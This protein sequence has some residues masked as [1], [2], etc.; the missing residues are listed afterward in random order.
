MN[1]LQLP[2]ITAQRWAAVFS[3]TRMGLCGVYHKH[4]QTSLRLCLLSLVHVCSWLLWQWCGECRLS[5][6]T[7]SGKQ[8]VHWGTTGFKKQRGRTL[9][10]WMFGLMWSTLLTLCAFTS[11]ISGL[12]MAVTPR[13][14]LS[15]LLTMAPHIPRRKQ[16][17]ID[18]DL[19]VMVTSPPRCSAYSSSYQFL[20]LGRCSAC[21]W[22]MLFR[23][24]SL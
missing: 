2:E 11:A 13:T 19:E 20:V 10:P 23:K 8:K 12:H 1:L 9:W 15:F 24:R 17:K 18:T 7:C 4:L 3:Q 5:H 14:D 21:S 22:I 16:E 6:P